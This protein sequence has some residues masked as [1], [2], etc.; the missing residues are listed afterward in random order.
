MKESKNQ[1]WFNL[2][3]MFIIFIGVSSSLIN[4]LNNRSLWLDEAMLGINIVDKSYKQLLMP[5]DMNQVAP[6]GFLY[7]EKLFTQIFGKVDW[8]LK[9]FPFISYL[10][11]ICLL[12]FF[13][14]KLTENKSIVL[15]ACALFSTNMFIIR[16]SAEVKQY[17]S[18]IFISLLVFTIAVYYNSFKRNTYLVYFSLLGIIAIGFSNIAIIGLFTAGS[19]IFL[20]EIKKDKKILNYRFI[21]F[22]VWIVSFLVYYLFFINNHPTKEFMTRYWVQQK[23]FLPGN[24]F[25]VQF[26]LF[27]YSK[28]RMIL[29][30]L[31]G[32]KYNIFVSLFAFIMGLLFTKRKSVFFLCLFP[33]LIHLILS[34]F[35][36][37]PFEKRTALYLMPFF[38]LLI[39]T[40]IIYSFNFFTNRF[41]K[42]PVYILLAF[43]VL[44]LI[45]VLKNIPTENEEVKK[46]LSYIDSKIQDGDNINVYFITE[47]AY[48]FYRNQYK[49]LKDKPFKILGNWKMKTW[50]EYEN[51]IRSISGKSWLVF[52]EVYPIGSLNGEDFIIKTLESFGH[53]VL[54]KRKFTGS[55]CYEII[56]EN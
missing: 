6:I 42:L 26:Y 4:L 56:K 41:I 28:T 47:P 55:S 43:L 5:L 19:Y 3:L 18:D 30:F 49:G 50:P 39:S 25:S 22:L 10:A 17:S 14:R 33:L 35:E 9:I 16:Y 20:I 40:G 29:P 46:S 37:Y 44:N 53:K 32:F 2:I 54:S 36:L 1:Y 8:A 27:L 7:L 51:Q 38:I 24:I 23:G 21:P 11:S 34:A 31:L 12:Y 15:L 52:S 45:H 13:G 48:I